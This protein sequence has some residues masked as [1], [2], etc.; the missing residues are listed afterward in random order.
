MAFVA[1]WSPRLAAIY[2]GLAAAIAILITW[3]PPRPRVADILAGLTAMWALTSTLVGL[4]DP[5]ITRV[6]AYLYASALLVFLAARHVV[7]ERA[8]LLPVALAHLAGCATTAVALI[9]GARD[10][11]VQRDAIF[12][13]NIRYGLDGININ[14]TSYTMVTGAILAVIL[15]RVGPASRALRAALLGTLLVFAY[16]ILLT[17]SKGA[18]LALFLG[19]SFLVLAR[20]GPQLMWTVVWVCVPVL[21]LLI[22]LKAASSFQAG[23]QWLDGLF[24]RETGDLSGRL[25]VWPIA[26]SA[27]AEHPIAGMGPG[28]FR[29]DNPLQIGPHNLLLTVGTDLG[30][31]GVILYGGTVA[32]A[33]ALAAKQ[34]AQTGKVLAGFAVITLLPVWMSGHWEQ[35]QGAWLVLAL[36]STIT[37]KDVVRRP[38]RHR[39]AA[40]GG[41][42][43]E[44]GRA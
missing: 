17:G 41:P 32:A 8:Q 34:A 16:A 42:A 10:G 35:S 7:R 18:T 22:P 6:P 11:G 44:F 27:W 31:V 38:G 25:E 1:A 14:Y 28:V 36:I 12:D 23:A 2:G 33:L 21:I 43:G 30:L 40:G 29:M 3:R 39:L 20:F 24:G 15:F 37:V 4:A 9:T 19:A 13:Y 5:S 26:A